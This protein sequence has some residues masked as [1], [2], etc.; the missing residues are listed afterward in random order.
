MKT[1]LEIPDDLFRRA[2]FAAAQKGVPL[3][4]FVSEELS[5]YVEALG[6]RLEIRGSFLIVRSE[7][8]S[9][10]NSLNCSRLQLCGWRW[11]GR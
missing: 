1:T 2:K 11:W 8:P 10:K 6:D 5:E 9:S 7:S 4:E 3:R